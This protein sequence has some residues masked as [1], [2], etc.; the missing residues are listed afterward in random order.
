MYFFNDGDTLRANQLAA[1]GVLVDPA[2]SGYAGLFR[3]QSATAAWTYQNTATGV[4][5]L[6]TDQ[7]EAELLAPE[8]LAL[9]FAYFDGTQMVEE[10]D[11]AQQGRLPRGVEIRLTLLQEPAELAMTTDSQEREALLRSEEN[12]V[13]Y[14]LYVR[15][16]N[17]RPR[18]AENPRRRSRGNSSRR[19]SSQDNSSRGGSNGSSNGSSSRSSNES[20]NDSSSN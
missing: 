5:V 10:W 16:P 17:L 15:L 4:S 2:L 8:V 20:S 7:A 18:R 19:G 14:R 12:A 11:T 6:T 13:E 9:E 3:S 1:L